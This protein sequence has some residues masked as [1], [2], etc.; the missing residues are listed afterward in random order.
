MGFHQLGDGDSFRPAKPV[1]DLLLLCSISWV[2][3]SPFGF[4]WRSLQA[5]LG[6]GL[7][8]A[9][10]TRVLPSPRTYPSGTVIVS[11]A[12]SSPLVL[13][14]ELSAVS[15][16][17]TASPSVHPACMVLASSA[18]SLPVPRYQLPSLFSC[19]VDLTPSWRGLAEYIR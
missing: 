3:K 9:T 12:S 6:L 2:A 7:S 13:A 16:A 17:E 5:R 10:L 18:R 8:G 19:R 11:F 14:D 1:D 15:N 4:D